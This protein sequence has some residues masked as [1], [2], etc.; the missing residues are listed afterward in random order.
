MRELLPIGTYSDII[1]AFSLGPSVSSLLGL[2]FDSRIKSRSSR[3]AFS[4]ITT[5]RYNGLFDLSHSKAVINLVL[6]TV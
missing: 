6:E 4:S 3:R 1:S 5:S 2:G